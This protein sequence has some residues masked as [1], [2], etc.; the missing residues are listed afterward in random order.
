M[1]DAGS[2]PAR[3]SRSRVLPRARAAASTEPR[4]EQEQEQEQEQVLVLLLLTFLA[5]LSRSWTV[6]GIS[7]GLSWCFPLLPAVGWGSGCCSCWLFCS[8]GATGL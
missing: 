3:P 5:V 4:E 1:Q 2:Q 7:L 6:P 8:W